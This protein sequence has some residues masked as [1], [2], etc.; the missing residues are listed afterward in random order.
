MV[1]SKKSKRRTIISTILFLLVCI[2][3]V[4]GSTILFSNLKAD[5]ETKYDGRVIA[6]G[7]A[8]ENGEVEWDIGE[9]MEE[10]TAK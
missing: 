4:V 8:A 2:G 5:N 10:D 9:N 3:L 1:Y 7:A 6:T